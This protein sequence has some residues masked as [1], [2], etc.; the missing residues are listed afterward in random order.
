VQEVISA[1]SFYGGNEGWVVTNSTFTPSAIALSQKANVKLI[2]GA[3]L[4]NKSV[5]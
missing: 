5:L 3:T 1:V 2:D 4:K